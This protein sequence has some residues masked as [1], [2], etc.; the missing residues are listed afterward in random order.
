ME[1]VPRKGSKM[2]DKSPQQYVV[3]V[4]ALSAI[5]ESNSNEVDPISVCRGRLGHRNAEELCKHAKDVIEAIPIACY[6]YYSGVDEVEVWIGGKSAT[7]R[8]AVVGDGMHITN[9]TANAPPARVR[10]RIKYDEYGDFVVAETD[11]DLDLAESRVISQ[12][13]RA[14]DSRL[15]IEK[16]RCRDCINVALPLIIFD[17]VKFVPKYKVPGIDPFVEPSLCQYFEDCVRM[18]LELFDLFDVGGRVFKLDLFGDLDY[19]FKWETTF[20][21]ASVK[22][23]EDGRYYY[24][25]G[26]NGIRY[27]F[28]YDKITEGD[29]VRF[30]AS[31]PRPSTYIVELDDGYAI[32]TPH[33][34]AVYRRVGEIERIEAT[35][36]P[37]LYKVFRKAIHNYLR[38][39]Y[40]G[41]EAWASGKCTWYGVGE[42]YC[43]AGETLE[44]VQ[45][46]RIITIS[47]HTPS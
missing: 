13:V 31:R 5:C 29:V 34:Y 12:M 24:Y 17:V 35:L 22:K 37:E 2:I 6:M 14:C 26:V 43:D 42:G 23:L 46:G 8:G 32:V 18:N 33:N 15:S 28:P 39:R 9:A 3:N 4:D 10:A 21:E 19:Y 30:I 40:A 1:K 16:F 25:W 36:P 20:V 27:G 44:V 38:D 41:R 7:W 45:P 47:S 11:L